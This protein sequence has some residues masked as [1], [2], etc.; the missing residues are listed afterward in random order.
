MEVD[1]PDLSIRTKDKDRRSKNKMDVVEVPLDPKFPFFRQTISIYVPLFPIGFDK[2]TTQMAEQHLEPLVNHYST[3]IKGLL[4]NYSN[5][6]V[7]DRPTE[8]GPSI[9]TTDTT[10]TLLVS[11]D[12]YGVGFGWLTFDAFMFKPARGKWMEGVLQLQS[13]AYIGVVCWGRF[14]ASIEAK[15]LPRTWKWIELEKPEESDAGGDNFDGEEAV[16][17]MHTT[18]YWVDEKG[19]KISGKLRFRIKNFDVG[20]S[21][22]YGYLSIEGT[23][24]NDAAEKALMMEEREEERRRR[25]TV[26]PTGDLRP[27]TKPMPAFGVTKFGKD[28]EEELEDAQARAV[29]QR[30]RP[31]TPDA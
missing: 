10:P 25:A 12:E 19:S 16:A 14:N 9:P 31:V 20:L 15:R 2:P 30:S 3:T 13:E 6:R 18:G 5:V 27:E 22:D 23:F 28:E 7:S 8:S 24:L 21:G 26:N 11:R 17:Q 4:L 1:I 29:Y